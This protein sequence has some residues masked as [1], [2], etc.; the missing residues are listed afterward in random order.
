MRNAA[1][2]ILPALALTLLS[3]AGCSAPVV[4]PGG[5][6]F[7]EFIVPCPRAQ[8]FDDALGFAHAS[9]LTVAVLEKSSGLI[10]FER[11]TLDPID[12]DAFCEFPLRDAETG[13][14]FSTFWEWNQWWGEGITDAKV[15]LNVL[16][17]EKGP[18]QTG[19]NVRGNW[20]AV[21]TDNAYSEV[22]RNYVLNST[23]SLE[24]ML[25]QS[26]IDACDGRSSPSTMGRM[27]KF[28]DDYAAL[29]DNYNEGKMKEVEYEAQR[30][31][32]LEDFHR[33]AQAD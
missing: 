28:S 23:G 10:K 4:K 31:Q 24:G 1:R 3:V 15:F 18:K 30:D 5:I 26:L 17:S 12:L 20:S 13:A 8:V 19:V 6:S 9:N 2:A 14:P 29:R 7:R 21:I 32:L 25:R 16:M 11:A 33:G 27:R 22:T